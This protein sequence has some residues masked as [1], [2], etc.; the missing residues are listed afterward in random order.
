M[1]Q[2]FC[3]RSPRVTSTVIVFGLGFVVK[4]LFYIGVALFIWAL[5]L[6]GAPRTFLS[7]NIYNALLITTPYFGMVAIPLTLVIITGGIDLSV[8]GV[9]ALTRTLA[10]KQGIN[11]GV[12]A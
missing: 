2:L 1:P 3:G 8:G 6:I 5:F 9:I 10:V 11:C 7:Y 12:K 4:W